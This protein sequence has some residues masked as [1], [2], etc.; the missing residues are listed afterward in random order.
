MVPAPHAATPEHRHVHH[1]QTFELLARR[2][3]AKCDADLNPLCRRRE[4][5]SARVRGVRQPSFPAPAMPQWSPCGPSLE[6]SHNLMELL[7]QLVEVAVVDTA[8]VD[9]LRQCL[10]RRDPNQPARPAL[11]TIPEAAEYL[12]VPER[13][14]REAARLRKVRCTRLGKHVRFRIE[15][16]DELVAAGEQPVTGPPVRLTALPV[17]DR[18]RSRL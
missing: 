3:A 4:R 1:V 11:L 8:T 5:C 7:S 12:H 13:W 14:V 2:I 18:R 16:L 9:V 6:R 10:Q 15:H 17:Q